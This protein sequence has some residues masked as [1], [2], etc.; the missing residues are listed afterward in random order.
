MLAWAAYASTVLDGK[1]TALYA[2]KP[3]SSNHALAIARSGATGEAVAAAEAALAIRTEKEW[4]RG[5][6]RIAGIGEARLDCDVIYGDPA[7]WIVETA[8]RVNAS[9]IVVGRRDPIALMPALL[10]HTLRHV[11][12]E[13]D[14]PV[15]VV[16]QRD[17]RDA[18]AG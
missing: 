11:L 7:D 16:T 4:L 18:E 5:E 9:L 13:A 8:G 12:H 17:A 3:V 2:L 15:L 14:C 6:S 1:V 10:G